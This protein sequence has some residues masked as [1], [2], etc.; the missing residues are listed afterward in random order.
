[1]ILRKFIPVAAAAAAIFA[2]AGC[3]PT[4]ASVTQA[5]NQ[6]WDVQCDVDAHILFGEWDDSDTWFYSNSGCKSGTKTVKVSCQTIGR[7]ED[8]TTT[9]DC[10]Y[11]SPATEF[12][13]IA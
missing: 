12:T 3:N 4:K 11:G 8:K 13:I 9:W 1:M 5:I 2:F 10:S 7:S 6:R